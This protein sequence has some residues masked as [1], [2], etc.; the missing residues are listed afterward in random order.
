VTSLPAIRRLKRYFPTARIAVLTGGAS[1]S[2]WALEPAVD[3]LIEFDF[4]HA[5]SASG[6]LERSAADWRALRER[7]APKRFDLAVDLRKHWETRPVLQHTGARYLA[8]F[9]MKGKFPW[10][11]VAVEW[12]EDV[13]LIRKRA[14]TTDELIQLI[15]AIAAA[16]EPKRTVIAHPPAAFAPNALTG[17]PA[18]RRIFRKRVVCVHPAVGNE[19]RQ[20]PAEYFSLLIDQLIERLDVHVI[21]VGGADEVALGAE[22]FSAILHRSSVWSLI[23]RVKLGD[24][25]ALMA[26]CALFVGNNSGPQ[27]IAAGL[28]IPTVGIHSG[29]VDAREWGPLGPRALA[30]HRVMTCSPCYHSQRDECHR[31]IACL[32]GLLPADV[33]R[34]CQRMLEPAAAGRKTAGI[35]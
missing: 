2:V 21:L 30:I 6:L 24:L 19:L 7:L 3:E 13:P 8:G 18:A 28:G 5:R 34:L 20:W 4:F 11:D 27:H 14:Q 12:S 1:K 23:G 15:D 10:L 25:P 26:R 9:D 22:V 31:D 29:V 35:G 17:V 33:L 32:K 16:S